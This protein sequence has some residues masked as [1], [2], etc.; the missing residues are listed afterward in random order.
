MEAQRQRTQEMMIARQ[1]L[2]ASQPQYHQGPTAMG[3]PYGGGY[4]SQRQ[5]RGGGMG[6][7]ALPLLGGLAGGF[8]LGEALDGGF[9]GGFDG[10]GF[11]GG[12]F[13]GGGF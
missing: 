6:G 11:D 5:R 7:L 3:F 9:G 10:G 1:Q 12:G 8:L 13:D 2:Y 4:G